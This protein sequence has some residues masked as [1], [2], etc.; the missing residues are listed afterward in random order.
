MLKCCFATTVSLRSTLTDAIRETQQLQNSDNRRLGINLQAQTSP[1]RPKKSDKHGHHQESDI[2]C[3]ENLPQA[4][5]IQKNGSQTSLGVMS[6]IQERRK[7][8]GL[9]A[10]LPIHGSHY[11]SPASPVFWKRLYTGVLPLC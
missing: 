2:R 1:R 9:H 8:S 11:Q 6:L 5:I 10:R 7:F 4:K 3:S